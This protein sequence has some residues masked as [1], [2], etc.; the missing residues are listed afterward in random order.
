MTISIRKLL[1]RGDE[2]CI[3][4]GQLV[5]RPASGKPVPPEWFQAHS[6]ALIQEVLTTLG[7]E[8]YAY[9]G[10]TTGHYGPRK[11]PGLTLQ[12]LSA[13]T[14]ES[15]YAIFN[16]ELT[17]RR[18]TRA[19]K[20]GDPLPPGHFRVGKGSHLYR[21]WQ[22]TGRPEPKRLAALHDYLGNLAGILL[23]ADRAEGHKD[24]MKTDS[25][26]PLS[27]SGLE[28]RRAFLPDNTRTRPGQ[29]P[30]NSRTRLPDKDSAQA[31]AARGFQPDPTTC[32]E[33]HGKTV[34][35][36]HGYTGAGASPVRRKRPEEQT[37]EEWLADYSSP[38]VDS[39][40]HHSLM[41]EAR[42]CWS[43]ADSLEN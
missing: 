38:A 41:A 7:I 20:Q 24:R 2:V 10:H 21:F 30:D 22:V 40:S 25:L 4:R 3:E 27:V 11:L 33:S 8:A 16:V 6:K 12:L 14:H 1:S 43:D 36:E 23:T 42:W 37:C 19:G 32:E 35:S 15:A 34:I 13:V 28:V 9:S 26:R 17:R 31:L 5:I 29:A 18:T 39:A